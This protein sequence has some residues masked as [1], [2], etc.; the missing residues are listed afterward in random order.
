[1]PS[2][3]RAS[4][5]PFLA[6]LFDFQ[7]PAVEGFHVGDDQFRVN[8]LDIGIRVDLVADVRDIVVFN[9]ADDMRRGVDFADVA[10]K[11]VAKP[12]WQ[13]GAN[14]SNN[15]FRFLRNPALWAESFTLQ[16]E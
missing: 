9:A 14:Y 5:L 10:Q 2:L 6:K 1:M 3:K 15:F 13:P 4:L 11:L 7:P 12:D 8:D 16:R